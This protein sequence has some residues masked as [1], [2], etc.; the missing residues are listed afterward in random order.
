MGIFVNS[1]KFLQTTKSL[2]FF[3]FFPKKKKRRYMYFEEFRQDLTENFNKGFKL[4]KI[5]RLI[6]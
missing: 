4:K 1:V 3:H 6:P 2:Q 5:E